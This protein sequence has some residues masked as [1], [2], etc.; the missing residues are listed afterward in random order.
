MPPPRRAAA[1][2]RVSLRMP[3]QAA[4]PGTSTRRANDLNAA[5]SIRAQVGNRLP[6][7]GAVL[8][9]PQMLRS[10]H[11]ESLHVRQN[12]DMYAMSGFG[13]SGG[14]EI[15]RLVVSIVPAGAEVHLWR[16]DTMWRR[17]FSQRPGRHVVCF[18]VLIVVARGDVRVLGTEVASGRVLFH[19]QP[20]LGARLAA[21]RSP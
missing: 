20:P 8:P 2:G 7:G 4:E 19:V 21:E 15:V 11:S 13:C 6:R 10:Y 12:S 9:S 5:G 17:S 3:S 16:I 1:L 18:V 14:A